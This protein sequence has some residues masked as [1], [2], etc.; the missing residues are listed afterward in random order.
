MKKQANSR[1]CFVCG[2]NN[3]NGL[4]INFYDEEVGKV[5]A[6]VTVPGHFQGYP[7]I[8]HGGIIAA[9]LDEVSGRT[10]MSGENPG[11]WMVT[12]SLNIRYRKPVPVE[13]PLRLEG[14]LKEDRG[15]II[16]AH[17]TILD[18]NG[19]LLAES[20]AVMTEAPMVMQMPIDDLTTEDWKIYPD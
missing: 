7:G 10:V 18:E 2:V 3:N 12:A 11:R 15:L 5:S 19:V 9:M 4:K 1:H 17:G 20:D 16:R 13:K 14:T 6:R 8:V